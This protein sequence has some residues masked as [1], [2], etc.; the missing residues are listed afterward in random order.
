MGRTFRGAG[1]AALLV[2]SW[3][4]RAWWRAWC[5]FPDIWRGLP[6][7][8][9]WYYSVYET[10][11]VSA[12]FTRLIASCKRFFFSAPESERKPLSTLISQVF[13]QEVA[14]SHEQQWAER[15]D[16]TISSSKRCIH[17]RTYSALTSVMTGP[18][19]ELFGRKCF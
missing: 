6:T 19:V 3:V 2:H 11:L 16:T 10:S 14:F 12:T 13:V 18:G 9:S 8:V 1:V 4:S 15:R 17:V 7:M 5:S